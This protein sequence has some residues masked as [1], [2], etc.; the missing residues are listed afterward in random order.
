[1]TEF[2]KAMHVAMEEAPKH[3]GKMIAI[4]VDTLKLAGIGKDRKSTETAAR[5]E[6]PSGRFFI[7]TKQPKNK[8]F[9][10]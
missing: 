5:R 2:R 10:F 9:C 8:I 7:W 4:D 3:P 6:N 1:M